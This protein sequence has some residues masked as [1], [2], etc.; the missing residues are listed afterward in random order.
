M[1]KKTKLFLGGFIVTMLLFTC[2][3]A[4]L[5]D[6]ADQQDASAQVAE[7]VEEEQN[8][9]ME[10]ELVETDV[11]NG[12]GDTVIGTEAHIYVQKDDLTSLTQEQFKEFVDE[13]VK[14]S[15]HNYVTIIAFDTD[16][17][18]FFPGSMVEIAQYGVYDMDSGLLADVYGDIVLQEDG[19]YQYTAR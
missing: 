10:A 9:L 19:T 1:K 14:D 18:I 11:M 17:A 4:S 13:V 7:V 12:A 8:P 16:N 15:G 6:E 2:F 5:G 3:I